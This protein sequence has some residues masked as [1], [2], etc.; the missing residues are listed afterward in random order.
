MVIRDYLKYIILYYV[1]LIILVDLYK[2]YF[3]TLW[4]DVNI[5]KTV[6]LS[7]MDYC[8]LLKIVGF[9]LTAKFEIG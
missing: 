5:P 8:K 2:Q 6:P 7:S 9:N 1:S 4:L 3:R